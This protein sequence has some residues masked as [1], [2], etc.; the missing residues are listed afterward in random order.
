MIAIS[1][2]K[3]RKIQEYFETEIKTQR[4]NAINRLNNI[5]INDFDSEEKEYLEFVK[6]IFE[7]NEDILLWDLDIINNKILSSTFKTVPTKK[8]K[9]IVIEKLGYKE[10]R[11]NFYPKYF[12]KIGIKACVYCNSQLTIVTEKNQAKFEVDHYYPKAD[13]PFLSITLCNLY[14]ACASFNGIKGESKIEFSLYTNDVQSKEKSL[15]SFEIQPQAKSKYLT[16]KDKDILEIKFNEPS[17]SSP[18][19]RTFNDTFNI[20]GIYKTQLDLIE[21]LI[22]KSQIYNDAY[23]KTLQQSFYKLN[24]NPELFKRILIGNYTNDKE[25]H[26]RP[27][28]KITMD[29]AKQLGLIE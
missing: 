5:N 8:I 7:Q 26:K 18:S 4:V 23:L 24:L 27:M 22:I 1:I 28:S 21:E 17:Y 6:E 19:I 9:D 29:I 12:N 25:I 16:A 10:L 13:Y 11:K 3:V 15:Y 14:P 20:E 2:Q